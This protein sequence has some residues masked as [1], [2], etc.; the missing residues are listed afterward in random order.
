METLS[1]QD[2]KLFHQLMDS[3]LFF[4]N[5][6]LKA[7][8][9]C[10]TLG[11][12]HKN[13]VEKTIPIRKIVF[14]DNTLID[15]YVADNPDNLPPNEI[16]IVLSWKKSLEDDFYLVKYEQEYALFLH[17]KDQKVY[18]VKGIFDSFNEKFGGYVPVMLRIRLLPFND[19]LIYDGIFFPYQISFGGGIR[20]SLKIETAA[21]IQR[22]GV[23]TSL[24]SPVIE[25]KNSDEEMLRF[26]LKSGDTRDRYYNEIEKLRRRSPALE[27]V[28]FRE[29]ASVASRT[30]KKGLKLNGIKGHFAVLV[31][32]IV[33]SALTEK[34]LEKNI[35]NIVPENKQSWI[36]EFKI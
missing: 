19:V 2:A 10:N 35:K 18:G 17:S 15:E 24:E 32:S 34:E 11:E 27:A 31:N 3:L 26:Y 13:N 33:A 9:N 28:Y 4:A 6:K 36:Y 8:K 20:S 1:E 29:E 12:F 22:L 7:I 30:I 25:R 5:K 14:S 16:K 23:I 21:A